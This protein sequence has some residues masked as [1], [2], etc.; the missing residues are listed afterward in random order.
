V[1][2]LPH[3]R[4]SPIFPVG[5]AVCFPAPHV[6]LSAP[7]FVCLR[8]TLIRVF[9]CD[10]D[11]RCTPEKMAAL[12]TQRIK[13]FP[14]RTVRRLSL[15]ASARAITDTHDLLPCLWLQP[16]RVKMKQRHTTLSAKTQGA[17]EVT[18]VRCSV[19]DREGTP[20]SRTLGVF[21]LFKT[22]KT[23]LNGPPNSWRGFGLRIVEPNK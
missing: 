20:P 19:A 2:T 13:L 22:Q 8:H 23:R 17:D 6:P 11:H 9:G 1:H 3:C 15:R 21:T 4:D 7:Y 14:A 12:Y 16:R 18:A 5:H 10:P